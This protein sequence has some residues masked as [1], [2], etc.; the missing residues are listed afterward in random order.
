VH[1]RKPD[2]RVGMLKK[3]PTRSRLGNISGMLRGLSTERLATSCDE[4]EDVPKTKGLYGRR[5]LHFNGILIAPPYAALM[6][7]ACFDQM[8]NSPGCEKCKRA[9]I[10][11]AGSDGTDLEST[12]FITRLCIPVRS[13]TLTRDRTL[14][15][16]TLHRV[17]CLAPL[18]NTAIVVDRDR[19]E[20][21]DGLTS[22]PGSSIV[23][24]P[25][26]RGTVPA[27]LWGL[28]RLANLGRNTI[29]G[30]FPGHN[31]FS[32]DARFI[33]HVEEATEEVEASRSL[34][35]VLGIVPTT[36]ASS[37]GWIEPGE[38]IFPL[39]PSLFRVR[40]FWKN[41]RTELAAKLMLEGCL[42]NSFVVV[43]RAPWLQEVIGECVPALYAAFNA[44]FASLDRSGEMR[45]VEELYLN[46]DNCDFSQEVLSRCPPGLAVKRVEDVE[47]NDFGKVNPPRTLGRRSWQAG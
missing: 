42:W 6:E 9:A 28:R 23:A 18:R 13:G 16:Q 47:R 34:S 15:K 11:L 36:A 8:R 41:P 31:F 3:L 26:N 38:R 12:E 44:A 40:R 1:S 33:S 24:Q 10:I 35:I 25:S 2:A 32:S 17:G 37:A 20:Y 39:V 4:S 21:Y 46:M 29:V 5:T 45:A 22:L 43:A 7:G 19:L 30:V 14:L 27:I